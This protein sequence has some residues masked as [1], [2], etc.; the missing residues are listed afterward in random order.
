[1]LFYYIKFK[2]N[3]YPPKQGKIHAYVFYYAKLI[4]FLIIHDTIHSKDFV[5]ST[6]AIFS[7]FIKID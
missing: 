3:D 1:M 2:N 5:V 4:Y 6:S 7:I